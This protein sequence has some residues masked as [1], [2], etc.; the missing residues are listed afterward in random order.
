M[1]KGRAALPRVP[2]SKKEM[3]LREGEN[4]SSCGY[5]A[6]GNYLFIGEALVSE[7]FQQ[8]GSVAVS[9]FE[10]LPHNAKQVPDTLWL[11]TPQRAQQTCPFSSGWRLRGRQIHGVHITVKE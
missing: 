5:P 2:V 8:G 10:H 3:K 9:P 6:L 11:P 1:K 4:E 7:D